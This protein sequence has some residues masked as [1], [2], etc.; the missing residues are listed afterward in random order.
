MSNYHE[1]LKTAVY[2]IGTE[3]ERTPAFSKKTLFV[4]GYQPQDEILATA[5]EHKI[6][7]IYLGANRSFTLNHDWNH[8]LTKLLDSK[9]MTV[10]LDYQASHH[11]QLTQVLSRG[12]WQCRSFIPLITVDITSINTLNQNLT[13]K[14]DDP[15]KKNDGVW[16]WN[17]HEIMDSNKF[18]GW[19]EYEDDEF[20]QPTKVV[21]VPQ[22]RARIA[23]R[24][25]TQLNKS[26]TAPLPVNPS[27]ENI[28]DYYSGELK[29]TSGSIGSDEE[30]QKEPELV[31]QR[32]VRKEKEESARHRTLK[33]DTE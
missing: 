20:I 22:P 1:Q 4:V 23:E 14:I 18:T 5:K 12:V 16:C 15:E 9:G 31:S 30:T 10:T 19:N 27:K 33:K 32:T 3:I 25:I 6:T 7:H 26:E 11:K 29:T 13:V 28:A 17:Q 2:F 21:A 8:L 24:A